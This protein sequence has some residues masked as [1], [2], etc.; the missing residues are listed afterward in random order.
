[1]DINV[2]WQAVSEKICSKCIDGDGAGNCRLHEREECALK[3]HFP[4]IIQT[5]LSIT[6]DTVE[7]YVAALRTNVC[8]TC[9]HNSSD[10]KCQVR[11]TVDCGLDRY[12]P[13]VVSAIE[14]VRYKQV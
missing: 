1:M 9:I 6:S 2:Y 10:G 3:S 11:S 8:T 5:V 14:E 4:Q 13:L 12:Y 7:P